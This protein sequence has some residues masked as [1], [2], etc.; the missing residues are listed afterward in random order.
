MLKLQNVHL[1]WKYSFKAIPRTTP[2]GNTSS[3]YYNVDYTPK[4]CALYR[5]HRPHSHQSSTPTPSHYGI[6]K[7]QMTAN[8]HNLE[9]FTENLDFPYMS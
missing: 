9:Y 3:A 6:S 7:I 1:V 5:L 8:T 4:G 2:Y